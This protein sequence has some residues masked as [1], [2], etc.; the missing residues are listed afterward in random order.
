MALSMVTRGGNNLCVCHESIAA[1]FTKSCWTWSEKML[2]KFVELLSR[3]NNHL[4]S[5]Q[6]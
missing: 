4:H 5:V 2:L 6:G 3:P 1:I